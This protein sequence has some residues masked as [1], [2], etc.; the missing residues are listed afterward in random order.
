MQS[1]RSQGTGPEK[2]L[3]RELHRRGFRFR[4]HRRVPGASRRLID[5][6]FPGARVAVLVDG[7]FWHGCPEHGTH[8]RSNAGYWRD[9]IAANRVRDADTDRRLIEAGW[10]PVRI[11]EHEV[12]SLAADR[13]SAVLAVRRVDNS[14]GPDASSRERSHGHRRDGSQEISSAAG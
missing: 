6:A 11:W 14:A 3:R 12:P 8:P 10:I 7:C 13:V 4:L 9:K 5:I 2:A 1:Q